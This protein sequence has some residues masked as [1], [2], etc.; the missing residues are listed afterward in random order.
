MFMRCLFFILWLIFSP[1]SFGKEAVTQGEFA[2]K[3][4]D[5]LG[6]YGLDEDEAITLLSSLAIGSDFIPQKAWEK[7]KIASTSFIAHIQASIQIILK[8][9]AID[10]GV[11]PP[12]TLELVIFELPPAPQRVFFTTENGDNALE[13]KAYEEPLSLPV[14]T[15]LI[16]PIATEV[17]LKVETGNI[18]KQQKEP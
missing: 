10:S 4:T 8:K 15:P 18:F 9:L 5:A 13:G 6:H 7:N 1:S 2:I 14:E 11:N 17:P 12:P 3:L 16:N